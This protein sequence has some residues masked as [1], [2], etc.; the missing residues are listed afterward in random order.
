MQDEISDGRVTERRDAIIEPIACSLDGAG[1]EARLEEWRALRRD[2]LIAE[3]RHGNV[4]TTT[5][6]PRGDVRERLERLVEA[7]GAC[8]PFLQLEL[9]EERDALRLDT[10]VPPEAEA[11]FDLF[12]SSLA[13]RHIPLIRGQAAHDHVQ[14]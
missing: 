5:W 13:G 6:S 7:E 11:V 12:A 2:A 4:R 8:C 10:T 1:L 9:F 14:A 3:S